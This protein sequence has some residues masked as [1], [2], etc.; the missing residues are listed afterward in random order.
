MRNHAIFPGDGPNHCW[1]IAIFLVLKMA[2]AANLD[3]QNVEILGIGTLPAV[4]MR[5]GAKFRG[6][7][8]NRCWD[9]TIFRFYKMA[10]AAIFDF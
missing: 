1:D 2:A 4:K 5:H 10:A 9:M 3:F 7:W 8:S 6:G